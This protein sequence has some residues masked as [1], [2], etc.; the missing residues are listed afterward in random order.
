VNPADPL[1][2]GDFVEHWAA[3]ARE[4]ARQLKWTPEQVPDV[5]AT[6]EKTFGAGWLRG[7]AQH[8]SRYPMTSDPKKHPVAHLIASPHRASVMQLIEL[9]VYLRSCACLR[10]FDQVASHLRASEQF[11]TARIQLALAHRLLLAGVE[12]LELEP[13]ADAGRRA[14]LFFRY[15]GL[16]HLVECYEP[17]AERNAHFDD[18][19]HGG[20]GRI[21]HVAR[22]VGRR[23]IV[24]VDLHGDI[25]SVDAAM[26]IQIEHETQDVIPKLERR[27]RL[28]RT[29]PAFD[30]EVIDTSGINA[31]QVKG[32]AFSLAGPGAWIVAPGMMRRRDVPRVSRDGGA[33]VAH[34]GWFVINHRESQDL[35]AMKRIADVVESKVG[36]V[37]RSEDNARGLMVVITDFAV[38]AARFRSAALP[39]VE[40]L[41][42]KILGTHDGLAGVV[43]IKHALDKE[44][45]PYVGGAFIEGREG[46]HLDTLWS[47]VELRERT[48]RVID[49]WA[50]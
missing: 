26:R 29:F 12:N 35:A 33:E 37:R 31:D 16:N 45:G 4:H 32:M 8:P 10:G 19:L 11:G 9:A 14:D 44:R 49:D 50:S 38:S 1:G 2:R 5:V 17:A 34:L 41:R 6:L 43:L 20:I 42:R 46:A 30:V 39:L 13:R 27:G 21:L 22:K 36:Q 3:E 7:K 23:V 28:A 24:R 15:G 18:L 40:A 47:A 48:H 25:H